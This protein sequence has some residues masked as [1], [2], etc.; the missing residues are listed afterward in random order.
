MTIPDGY[1]A[2]GVVQCSVG[3]VPR[4]DA[5]SGTAPGGRNRVYSPVPATVTS[6]LPYLVE[7]LEDKAR[8]LV[9]QVAVFVLV[10]ELSDGLRLAAEDAKLGDFGFLSSEL[11][12]EI[13][14]YLPFSGLG[15][16]AS[17]CSGWKSI[18]D[19]DPLWRRH[20]ERFAKG[21]S[22]TT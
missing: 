17:V 1:P 9:G 12:Y 19:S 22:D 13:F 10:E 15:R 16:A 4:S 2:S 8:S 18:S 14:S 3:T 21:S 6:Q 7:R 5:A 20:C 11:I